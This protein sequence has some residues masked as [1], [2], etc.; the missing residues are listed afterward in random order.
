M[1]TTMASL[2]GAVPPALGYGADGRARMPLG[3]IIVGGL[4]VSRLIT[5]CVTSALLLYLEAFQEERA[6]PPRIPAQ[7]ARQARRS[8]SHYDQ[9]VR[10]LRIE[11]WLGSYEAGR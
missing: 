7:P 2:M 5:L 1:M 6:R 10:R 4:V 11:P 8:V 3:L 9:T